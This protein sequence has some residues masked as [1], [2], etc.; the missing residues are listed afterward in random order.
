MRIPTYTANE[1]Y[2][3]DEDTRRNQTKLSL[4]LKT[5]FYREQINQV[6][7]DEEDLIQCL[8]SCSDEILARL[9]YWEERPCVNRIAEDRGDWLPRMEKNSGRINQVVDGRFHGEVNQSCRSCEHLRN[10]DELVPRKKLT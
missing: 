6:T 9:S 1:D 4:A 10:V 5:R 8:S 7:P 3:A 2:C